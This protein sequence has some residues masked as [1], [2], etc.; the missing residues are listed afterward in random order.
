MS[1]ASTASESLASV[2]LE[3]RIMLYIDLLGFKNFVNNIE[4]GSTDE[5]KVKDFYSSLLRLYK[6]DGELTR[7]H[8]HGVGLRSSFSFFSD[9]IVVS[10]PCGLD[11]RINKMM[12]TESNL[13]AIRTELISLFNTA[14]MIQGNCLIHLGL[15][16]NPG[17]SGRC[18]A[19]EARRGH[20]RRNTAHTRT[21]GRNAPLDSY[22]CRDSQL[23][24][25]QKIRRRVTAKLA[26]RSVADFP[27]EQS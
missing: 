1:E 11:E 8:V 10:N 18:C 14:N 23:F 17:L 27:R 3:Q 26:I 13:P 21:R 7:T 20:R 15:V 12:K 9:S 4:P 22:I 24:L 2:S 25:R 19:S 16:S 5:K 6:S